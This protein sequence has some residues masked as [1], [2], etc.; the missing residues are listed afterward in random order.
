M[1]GGPF[2]VPQPADNRRVASRS[3]PA[4]RPPEEPQQP[5]I[6]EEAK[7]VYRS[8]EPRRTVKEKK[9]LKKI[10]LPIIVVIVILIVGFV[11]WTVWSNS[12]KSGATA[13]NTSEYQAVF[14]TNGQV[15]FGKLSAFNNDSMKL[16]DI[17]Y[18]QTQSSAG[19]GSNNPQTTSSDTSSSVQLVKLGSE[20]HGP[21]DEMILSKDQVLFYENLK[22]D[23]KVA[24]SIADYKK[25]A[26]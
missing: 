20:V 21:E 23:G 7:T 22:P 12:H 18:L 24:Q 10:L 15:Y 19:T 26:K 9:G 1:D 16:N 3:E 14:F 6:K 13:I 8:E 2:R 17:Y 25:S 5:I 4:S 11:G